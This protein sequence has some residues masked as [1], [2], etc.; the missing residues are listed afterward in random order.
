MRIRSSA[1]L[2][3][4]TVPTYGSTLL[5]TFRATHLETVTATIKSVAKC[6]TKIYLQIQTVR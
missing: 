4:G 1:T 5:E 2:A 6:L 3:P